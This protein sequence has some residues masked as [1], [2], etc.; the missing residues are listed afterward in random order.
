MSVDSEPVQLPETQRLQEALK[1]IA[2]WGKV[3]SGRGWSCAEYA[4]WVLDGKDVS[5]GIGNL[6]K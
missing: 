5:K 6:K 2:E 4:Q 1:V 3:N